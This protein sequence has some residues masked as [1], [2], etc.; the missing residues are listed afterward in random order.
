MGLQDSLSQGFVFGKPGG[1]KAKGEGS[2]FLD[3]KIRVC[4][5]GKLSK[6]L[7]VLVSQNSPL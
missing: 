5:E 6:Y 1:R 4:K 2:E 3:F 7:F